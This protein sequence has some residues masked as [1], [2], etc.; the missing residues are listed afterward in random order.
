[1]VETPGGPAWHRYNGD[2]YGEHPDGSPFDGTGLGRAWP[3]LV[4]ERAHFELAAGRTRRALALLD[5]MDELA[6]AE[7]LL[8]EQVWDAP[9]VP[10]R[11]LFFG[12]PSGSAMPL[13]WAHAEYVKLLRS[14]RD[15]RVFDMPPQT[16]QRY[17]VDRVGS[18][19]VIWRFNQKCRRV[20]IGKTLRI[21]VLESA[22]I[23]WSSDGW[24]TA[25]DAETGDTRL[26]VHVADLPT[27]QFPT[28]TVVRFTFHWPAAD[29]WEGRDFEVE[30]SLRSVDSIA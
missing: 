1:R 23:H 29:R 27:S 24:G 16:V 12:R 8:P 2:G 9:D 4:G 3:L 21:E 7:G 5:T 15:R 18:P 11:E 28:G 17:L 26:G 10:A 30:V 6:S 20:E 22:R 25:H 19:H 14:L 13:A